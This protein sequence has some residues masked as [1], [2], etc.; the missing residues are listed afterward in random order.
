[1]SRSNPEVRSRP[2]LP[3]A[4]RGYRPGLLG[5][6]L[7]ATLAGIPAAPAAGS[8]GAPPPVLERQI[9]GGYEHAYPFRLAA[10][11]FL[12]AIVEQVGSD[13][14]VRIVDP[15]GRTLCEMDSADGVWW[16]EEA[17]VVAER[18]G[19]YRVMVRPWKEEAAP[20]LYRLRVSGPRPATG[21]DR[22]RLAA[23]R[24]SIAKA[25]KPEPPELAAEIERRE[26]ALALWRQLGD[27][28][29]EAETLYR[30]AFLRWRNGEPGGALPLARRTA[31]IWRDL[32][33]RARAAKSLLL[34][35]LQERALFQEETAA[36]TL[37]AAQDLA[38]EAGNAEASMEIHTERGGLYLDIEQPRAAL[39]HLEAALRL[40]RQ[41]GNQDFEAMTLTNLGFAHD[42]LGDKQAAL[43]L[44]GQ[45]LAAARQTGDGRFL[46]AALIN[47]GDL[48]QS[49]GDW[50]EALSHYSQA[51]DISRQG[52]DPERLEREATILNNWG[53][54]LQRMEQPEKALELLQESLRLARERQSA[55]REA[56][57]VSNLAFLYIRLGEPSRAL[58][59]GQQA[60]RL[61]GGSKILEAA[62]RQALGAAHRVLGDREIA[63]REL[64]AA[65]ALNR[66]R[67]DPF[68][69]SQVILELA[70]VE[71]D[72]GD[73]HRALA[74]LEKGIEIVESLRRRMID[75]DLRASF[76]ASRQ[77]YYE[78]RVDTLMALHGRE[79]EAG[80]E[81]AALR[82]SEARRARNLLETLN[83]AGFDVFQGADPVLVERERRLRA[84]IDE[85]ENRRLALLNAGAG[86]AAVEEALRE[87]EA[88]IAEHKQA[89]SQLVE[90]S[91]RYAALTQPRPLGVQEIQRQVVDGGALL[92]EYSL[93]EERSYL[94]AVS[95]ERVSSHALP[96]RARIEEVA[97]RF[98][99]ALTARN[100][101]PGRARE[102]DREAAMAAAE[103]S[104]IVLA[105]VAGLLRGQPLLVV[106][107]GALQY[108][109]FAALTLP[110]SQGL[111]LVERHEVVSLPSASALAVLRRE[112]AGRPAAPKTLAVLADPVFQ[113]SDARLSHRTAAR[114]PEKRAISEPRGGPELPR[115]GQA[116][117]RHLPRLHFSQR[118]AA[119]IAG[120]V[121]E[122]QRFTALGFDA[123]RAMATGGRLKDYRIV[124]FAT[125]G[126]VDSQTPEMSSL[127][128]SLL[129]DKGE[130]QNGFLR[131]HDIYNLDLQA[132]LVVL[133]ACQTALGKE[134]RG[135]GL[136]GLTRGF[137]YAGAA[138]VVASLWSVDDHATSELMKR[139]YQHMIRDQ[140]RPAAALR[141][142]QLEMA[143]HP[144]FQSPYYW[145]GFSL[146]GEWR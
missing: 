3:R 48:L 100:T 60:L 137:M 146:Q 81:S 89:F 39:P 109:P 65:L 129:D 139:F 36:E 141:E 53:L 106:A 67:R 87:V 2:R 98:Y 131:L 122:S 54:L 34:A 130:P 38:R 68:R 7:A 57:A 105:P 116:D 75:E 102:A 51:L 61:A 5:L 71:R 114:R 18:P 43:E 59:H 29:R 62:A 58:E 37:A 92:L 52:N 96:G 145:A 84:A 79:P 118:E 144:L 83:R 31:E 82:A 91:P 121:P 134:I 125:H 1:M 6:S 47:T 17:A 56:A 110:G 135:E 70:R 126:L 115:G 23:L 73:L 95:R 63:R 41:I 49:L 32:G 128:L 64:E 143:R 28:R 12:G 20:G 15:E 93:G 10:G 90:S 50:D 72:A 104:G 77:A 26:R 55:E 85:R 9:R 120:L 107:D 113:K 21:E 132:D 8:G 45:A 33:D 103:L 78:Y 74:H 119:A 27:R 124:H 24:D 140:R 142:A 19:T 30:L 14:L 138:R 94:W 80:H 123:S 136:V 108:V 66:E 101:D 16:E 42:E 40:A 4:S 69:E 127:V 13:L 44:Y 46:A 76:L 35:A 99:G 117:P 133:S 86:A 22:L 25:A 97:R 11:D 88:A 111:Q 112:L